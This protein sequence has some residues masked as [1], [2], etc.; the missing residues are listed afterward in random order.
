MWWLQPAQRWSQTGVRVLDCATRNSYSSSNGTNI[1]QT[2]DVFDGSRYLKATVL[3]VLNWRSTGVF[4]LWRGISFKKTSSNAVAC[5]FTFL[6]EQRHSIN[7]WLSGVELRV[8]R[9]VDCVWFQNYPG[10]QL[11]GKINVVMIITKAVE[12]SDMRWRQSADVVTSH[13]QINCPQG[14]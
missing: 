7:H 13:H 8:C 5:F 9:I 12:L 4:I 3:C 14:A 6:I 2:T 11:D 10:V 1:T